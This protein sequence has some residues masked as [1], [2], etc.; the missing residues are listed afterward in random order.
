MDHLQ[1]STPGFV[2]QMKGRLTTSRYTGAVIFVD[3]HSSLPFGHLCKELSVEAT[4]EA[5][6]GYK[7]YAESFGRSLGH[8]HGDNGRFADNAFTAHINSQG[9]TISFCGVG[10]HHQ[11]GRAEKMIRD[12]SGI[13]NTAM[14]HAQGKWPNAHHP[15]LWPYAL[16]YAIHIKANT[17]RAKDG[18]IPSM[19]FR[20]S[21]SPPS[22][23]KARSSP[24]SRR[25]RS[26][27]CCRTASN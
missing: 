27:P 15:S 2:A 20:G 14:I 26:T 8:L 7:R 5:L 9:I 23:K 22:M 6:E 17:P 1:S 24:F 10:S 16:L 11:N 19:I 12:I 21:N 13:A 4:I 25:R 18:L 3:H